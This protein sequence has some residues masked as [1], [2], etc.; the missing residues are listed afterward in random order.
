MAFRTPLEGVL[1]GQTGR[2]APSSGHKDSEPQRAAR[3]TRRAGAGAEDGAAV[4][5][6]DCEGYPQ[7]WAKLSPVLSLIFSRLISIWSCVWFEKS[8]SGGAVLLVRAFYLYVP[9]CTRGGV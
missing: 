7:Q 9:T 1:A 3:V 4:D 2:K 5:L 6:A 8:T